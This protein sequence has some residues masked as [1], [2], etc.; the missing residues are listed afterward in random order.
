MRVRKALDNAYSGQEDHSDGS[1]LWAL[2]RYFD[3]GSPRTISSKRDGQSFNWVD[4]LEPERQLHTHA[5]DG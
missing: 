5:G 4:F 1:L 2:G 3:P